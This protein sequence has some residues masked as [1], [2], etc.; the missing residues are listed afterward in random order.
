M[1]P[2]PVLGPLVFL[3][4]LEGNDRNP[5]TDHAL[6]CQLLLQHVVIII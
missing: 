2:L 6:D 1:S 5:S 3:S 4:L